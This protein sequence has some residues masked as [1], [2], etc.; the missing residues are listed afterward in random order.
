[1]PHGTSQGWPAG[2]GHIGNDPDAPIDQTVPIDGGAAGATPTPPPTIVGQVIA[3]QDGS[4]WQ[5]GP[6]T[7]QLPGA[8]PGLSDTAGGGLPSFKS[9]NQLV[10]T[11]L[12]TGETANIESLQ[13]PFILQDRREVV[14][15]GQGNITSERNLTAAQFDAAT[16]GSGTG[17]GGAGGSG[18]STVAAKAPDPFGAAVIITDHYD[19]LVEREEMT[20]EDAAAAWQRDFDEITGN[21][22]IAAEKFAAQQNLQDTATRRGELEFDILRSSLPTNQQLNLGPFGKVPQN[23]VNVQDILTQGLPSLASQYQNIGNELTPIT[24]LPEVAPLQLPDTSLLNQLPGLAN[25]TAAGFGG[26]SVN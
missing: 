23:I 20:A 17:G 15:D 3:L 22:R 19:R 9:G 5:V 6:P 18:P 16:S 11:N 10:A 1:M 13:G 21:A 8:A 26:F 4:Y 2:Y 7:V 25:Q 12:A 24:G 14:T